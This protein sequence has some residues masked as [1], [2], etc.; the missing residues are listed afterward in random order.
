MIES[1]SEDSL[2]I[3][4]ILDSGIRKYEVL[5]VLGQGGFGITY[6]VKSKIF[7][8]NIPI[9][10]L[11][12]IKEFYDRA[13]NGRQGLSVVVS[14]ENKQ[15]EIL[16]GIEDFITEASRLNKLSLDHPN[17]VRVNEN[18]K[19]NNTVYYVME[20]I[21]GVSLRSYVRQSKSLSERDALRLF[22]PIAE[23]IGYLH[24]HRV[25]HLDIKPDNILIR[26]NGQPV[27]I[28][29]GLSKHYN[30]SGS[31]TSKI[32]SFGH[33]DGYS[34][35]EQYAGIF[36]F[37][38]QTDI[39]ALAATL[40]FMLTGKDPRK[41]TDINAMIIRDS[42]STDIS[43]Q[44]TL[45]ILKAMEKL[46][47]N[48]TAKVEDL[49]EDL[50]V[51]FD[52]VAEEEPLEGKDT[53]DRKT[54]NFG[55]IGGIPTMRSG[56]KSNKLKFFSNRLRNIFKTNKEESRMKSEETEV[57]GEIF[58][59]RV[60]TRE[61]PK[62][63]PS[64]TLIT[65]INEKSLL[66]YFR[67]NSYVYGGANSSKAAYWLLDPFFDR[68][69]HKIPKDK[70][71][72]EMNNDKLFRL[73]RNTLLEHIK[74]HK[75]IIEEGKNYALF[76]QYDDYLYLNELFFSSDPI[77]KV[78][79][80][81]F[82]N[83]M[84]AF[85]L[86]RHENSD[87]ARV[88]IGI[89]SVDVDYQKGVFRIVGMGHDGN[90]FQNYSNQNKVRTYT[91]T[92]ALFLNYLIE[93][94]QEYVINLDVKGTVTLIQSFPYTIGTP[95]GLYPKS[96]FVDLIKKK[97][98]SGRD[99][100]LVDSFDMMYNSE[101]SIPKKSLEHGNILS[102]YIMDCLTDNL[103]WIDINVEE[104]LGYVPFNIGVVIEK[105]HRNSIFIEIQD[106]DR[107]EYRSRTSIGNLLKK[108]NTTKSDESNRTIIEPVDLL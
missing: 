56:S 4:T 49:L 51:G 103:K 99:L 42:L 33:S 5:S 83:Q 2:P 50:Y 90:C 29:F 60:P 72:Y 38:P 11:F 68:P 104:C 10:A 13:E 75:D 55:M 6:K 48:R 65:F 23:A 85:S 14:N 94:L 81:M 8:D 43:E 78:E 76:S 41:A 66:I 64:P 32:K 59:E 1:R 52:G 79:E 17:I 101:N 12:A 71:Q 47:E 15:R 16:E 92:E 69:L 24:R 44:T 97:Q 74:I 95:N 107:K 80:L 86:I 88:E 53:N 61:M 40:L 54:H 45:A 77:A 67:G 100:C 21:E 84:A 58:E 93:G 9:M 18:F 62:S 105:D 70:D 7:V 63:Y 25:M 36:T 98:I 34:P 19:A 26:K 35:M 37:S 57:T 73:S 96:V 31:P 89:D 39:Y 87:I 3:G 102:L 106:N 46:K 108:A 30:L 82:A 27:I 28:D 20:Y 22:R 91:I